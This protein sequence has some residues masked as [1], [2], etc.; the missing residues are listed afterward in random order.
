MYVQ[1]FL[2]HSHMD[3]FTWFTS[4]DFLAAAALISSTKRPSNTLEFKLALWPSWL[5]CDPLT[6][7]WSFMVLAVFKMK[8]I[9]L[10]HSLKVV[11]D[12][13]VS[14]MPGNV[15]ECQTHPPV[16]CPRQS[17]L[18]TPSTVP[19]VCGWPWPRSRRGTWEINWARLTHS[20][21]SPT[22]L[23]SSRP[24]LPASLLLHRAMAAG[25]RKPGP[26]SLRLPDGLRIRF[27]LPPWR[28]GVE[29]DWGGRKGERWQRR[30]R[31]REEMC[32]GGGGE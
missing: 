24:N 29:R 30:R 14:K 31:R 27:E 7:W 10:F 25:H 19:S 5:R 2:C 16:F 9:F 4:L 17:T 32:R 11:L 21:G 15:N 8:V 1:N 22:P 20:A 3:F 23:H 13:G 26:P 28:E 6:D 12:G 18:Q